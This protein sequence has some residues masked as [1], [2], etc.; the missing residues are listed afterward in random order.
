MNDIAFAALQNAEVLE[1]F[2]KQHRPIKLVFEWQSINQ[3]GFHI[4][5]AVLD[6][7]TFDSKS[8]PSLFVD[9]NGKTEFDLTL[10]SNS[11]WNAVNSYLQ[12]TL[13]AKGARWGEGQ[14]CRGAD[15]V[16]VSKNIAP[17]QL[18]HCAANHYSIR[19]ARLCGRLNELLIRLSRVEGSAQDH[20]VTQR[21]A[22][23]SL[24]QL[25]AFS[26]P[27]DWPCHSLPSLTCAYYAKRWA[28]TELKT[29]ETQLR[30]KRHKSWKNQ[31][32]SSSTRGC[33]YIFHHLIVLSTSLTRSGTKSLVLMSSNTP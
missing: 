33:A 10:D 20:F 18:S 2:G 3:T 16:F 24:Q 21:T 12:K 9:D 23:K 22:D 14:Q 27:V 25:R 5:K 26:A 17:K 1:V 7:C 30:A 31:I 28:D 6:L 4:V 11:K 29:Y 32:R 8:P 13:L 15:P 19:V